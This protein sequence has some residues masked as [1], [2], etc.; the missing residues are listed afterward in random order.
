MLNA[1]DTLVAQAY[2]A[3]MYSLMGLHTQRAIVTLFTIPVI[4]I[5]TYT[6]VLELR[7]W[8]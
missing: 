4:I 7:A 6:G 1:L 8:N 3:K 5:W 2:G